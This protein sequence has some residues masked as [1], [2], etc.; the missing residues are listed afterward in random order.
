MYDIMNWY[1]LHGKAAS[2]N[3]WIIV[4]KSLGESSI[5]TFEMIPKNAFIPVFWC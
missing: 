1:K 3:D 5:I 4:S 2:G